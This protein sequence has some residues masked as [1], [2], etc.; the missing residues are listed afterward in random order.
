MVYGPCTPLAAARICGC[1]PDDLIHGALGGKDEGDKIRTIHDTTANHVNDRIRANQQE[2][3]TAPTINDWQHAAAVDH[4]EGRAP[5]VLLKAG[6]SKAH[7]RIKIVRKHWRCII[8]MVGEDIFINTV[9]TYGVAS[10]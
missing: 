7:R 6:M 5:S 2:K 9:G 4:Y 3:T 1:S 10:A 8:A